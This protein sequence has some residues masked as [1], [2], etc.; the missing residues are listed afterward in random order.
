LETAAEKVEK[1]LNF[2]YGL[3]NKKSRPQTSTA[4]GKQPPKTKQTMNNP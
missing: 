2:D 4:K 3:S 1:D